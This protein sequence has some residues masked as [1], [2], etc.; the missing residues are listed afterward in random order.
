[1]NR[2]FTILFAT[3]SEI[4]KDTFI[5]EINMKIITKPGVNPARKNK[6]KKESDRLCQN[7]IVPELSAILFTSHPDPLVLLTGT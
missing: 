7:Q 4:K 3:C 1:M 2:V 5:V 6:H